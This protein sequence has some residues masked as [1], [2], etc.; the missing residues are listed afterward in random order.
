[1]LEVER[2]FTLP[3]EGPGRSETDETSEEGFQGTFRQFKL[4]L[5]ERYVQLL[6]SKRPVDSTLKCTG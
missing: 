3:T 5:M 1:M 2:T 6:Q 4:G